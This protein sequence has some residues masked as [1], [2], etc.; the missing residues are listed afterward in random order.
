[1]FLKE[2]KMNGSLIGCVVALVAT[3]AILGGLWIYQSAE[4]AKYTGV[5]EELGYKT[6]EI[7]QY[8]S[9]NIF[10]C[11]D[12]DGILRVPKRAGE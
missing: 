7:G 11:V 4:E 2:E 1:M 12:E 10:L 8:A 6:F 9:T 3:A 5:C